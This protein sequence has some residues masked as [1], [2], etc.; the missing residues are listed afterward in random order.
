M[1]SGQRVPEIAFHRQMED[2]KTVAEGLNVSVLAATTDQKRKLCNVFLTGATGYLGLALVFALLQQDQIGHIYVLVRADT[3]DEAKQRLIVGAKHAGWWQSRYLN[4]LV[5]WL[6][7]LSEQRFGL[8][9]AQWDCLSGIVDPEKSIHG[10]IHS[11]AD[12]KWYK[13]YAALRLVNVISTCQL[14]ECASSSPVLQKYI[15]VST[16]PHL[17]LNHMDD[18]EAK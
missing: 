7:D 4:R 10:I 15:F 16:A 11:G 8:T 2:I 1:T 5:V 18:E 13:N 3:K 6:G 17:D 12:V 9:D 14:L